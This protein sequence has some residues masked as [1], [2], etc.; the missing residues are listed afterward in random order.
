MEAR[1]STLKTADSKG[2]ATT[3]KSDTLKKSS[4]EWFKLEANKQKKTHE[5]KY[6]FRVFLDYDSTKLKLIKCPFIMN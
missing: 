4:L 5:L 6:V 1:I 2:T 3:K